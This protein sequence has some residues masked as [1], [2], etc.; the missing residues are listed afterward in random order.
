MSKLAFLLIAALPIA[1]ALAQTPP[2]QSAS[3]AAY[4]CPKIKTL[5]CMPIVPPERR[6][7]CAKDFRDWAATHCPD[8]QIVY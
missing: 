3:P 1:G 7:L 8:L 6:A 4:V 5:N 2:A